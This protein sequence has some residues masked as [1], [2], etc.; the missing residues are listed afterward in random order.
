MIR[1]SFFLVMEKQTFFG[2]QQHVV[3]TIM[4]I[5]EMSR[6][7]E[8]DEFSRPHNSRCGAFKSWK[9]LCRQII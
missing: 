2:G 7:I 1:E 3:S 9:M 8:A 5:N 6:K 4:L